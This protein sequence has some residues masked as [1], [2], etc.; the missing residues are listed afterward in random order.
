MPADTTRRHFLLA[1]GGGTAAMLAATIPEPAATAPASPLD[2]VFGLISAHRNVD[3]TVKAIEA[4]HSRLYDLNMLISDDEITKPASAEMG[5]FLEL[6]EV[7]PTTLAG[8]VALVTYLDEIHK[9]D[10]WK[11][12]DN[13]ATPL[14]GNLAEAFNRFSA[15]S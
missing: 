9:K 11:F 13:Y 14:I 5:A 1:V 7:V 4:E 6:L 15:V 12:E 3:A 8:V 2:P 10:P